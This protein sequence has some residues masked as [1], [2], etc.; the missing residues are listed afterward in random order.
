[1]DIDGNPSDDTIEDDV[2]VYEPL[3]PELEKACSH[4]ECENE[5]GPR[6]RLC[7]KCDPIMGD[8]DLLECNYCGQARVSGRYKQFQQ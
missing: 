3:Y 4:P 5:S 6:R 2:P 1:M 7:D 8:N